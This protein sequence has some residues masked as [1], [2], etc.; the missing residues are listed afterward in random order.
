M[1][2]QSESLNPALQQLPPESAASARRSGDADAELV[3]LAQAG[4][5]RAFEAL[6]V[7]YQ[8]RIAHHVGRYVKRPS[9]VEDVVQEVFINAYRGLRTFK[10][11]SAFYTWLYRIAKNAALSFVARAR[12]AV[13]LHDDLLPGDVEEQTSFD[14]ADASDPE[15]LLIAKQI[16]DTVERAMGRLHP[17]LAEALLLYEVE[18]KAYREIAQ[19]LQIPIGTVRTRIF[20]AREFVAQKLEPVVGPVRDRRW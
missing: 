15:R 14:R 20:R 19:M 10:G 5:S 2:P 12:D 9:D 11:E 4:N 7:K 3:R 1:S 17:D 13:L 18:G 6:I 16:S 8:R